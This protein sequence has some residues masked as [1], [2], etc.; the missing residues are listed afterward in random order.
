MPLLTELENMAHPSTTKMPRLTA[1]RG[2]PL[3]FSCS[4]SFEDESCPNQDWD[5]ASPY[6]NVKIKI[7]ITI[8]F[9]IKIRIGSKVSGFFV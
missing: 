2:C 9:M 8:T 4:T 6:S 7:K 1:L 5:E 3:D